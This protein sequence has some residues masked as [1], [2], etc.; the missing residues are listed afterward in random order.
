ME[1]AASIL[2]I[3]RQTLYIN[4]GRDVL[5][6]GFLRNVKTNL[7]PVIKKELPD[8][9]LDEVDIKDARDELIEQ[10]KFLIETQNK[11]IRELERRIE[12]VLTEGKAGARRHSA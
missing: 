10:Q 3:S 7:V 6:T 1:E 9:T 11:L 4:L 2:S 12:S 5:E 8:F